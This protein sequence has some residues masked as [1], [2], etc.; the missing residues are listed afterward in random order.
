MLYVDLPTRPEIRALAAARGPVCVSLFLP[1]TPLTQGT[2]RDRLVLKN[3]AADAVKQLEAAR[4]D[5]RQVAALTEPLDD[6]IHA[7]A[8][9]RPRAPSLAVFAT[10]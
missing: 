9:W 1:T 8:F 4:A 2:D 3:L 7:D 6:L 5:K 10:P